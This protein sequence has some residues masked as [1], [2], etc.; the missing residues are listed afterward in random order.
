M[1]KTYLGII[2]TLMVVIVGMFAGVLIIMGEARSLID[3]KNCQT[4]RTTLIY[5]DE[6]EPV[7]TFD[8]LDCKE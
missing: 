2:I 7:K 3:P 5:Q 1:N 4:I 6:G 8:Y